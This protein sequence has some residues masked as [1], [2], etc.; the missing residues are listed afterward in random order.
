MST[1]KQTS[2]TIGRTAK[3]AG[4]TID[5]IRF[6]E[7]RGLLPMPQ[8]TANGYRLYPPETVSRLHF[9]RRA[10]GL[11][12]TL[13]EIHTLLKLQDMGGAKADV[14]ALTEHKLKQIEIKITDLQLMQDALRKL[15]TQCS[16]TGNVSNCPIIET[17]TVNSLPNSDNSS[18]E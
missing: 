12:F 10:K 16:G 13:D 2:L 9:I 5:T 4:V 8:R 14:K 17:L 1:E 15:N 11:G 6:Y 3:Q 18:T 7:H